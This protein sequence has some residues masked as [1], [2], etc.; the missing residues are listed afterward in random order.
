MDPRVTG[1]PAI[2]AL[3]DEQAKLEESWALRL[4]RCAF[5]TAR[6]AY[7]FEVFEDDG[8]LR[9]FGLRNDMLGDAVAYVGL[10]PMLFPD[11]FL[12][13]SLADLVPHDR[14]EA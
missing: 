11:I 2:F 14:R 13:C 9:V 12:R 3:L 5:G 7:A 8:S 1:T 4:R 10:E 6:G